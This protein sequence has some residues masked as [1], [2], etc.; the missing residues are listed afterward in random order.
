VLGRLGRDRETRVV[1]VR[2]AR[3]YLQHSGVDG[4]LEKNIIYFPIPIHVLFSCS[5][6]WW[7]QD[8]FYSRAKSDQGFI[9]LGQR[10][11]MP[12]SS[13]KA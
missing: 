12:C 5:Q 3:R 4:L 8:G 7:R 9:A 10:L 11:G 2:L 1:I 6:Q 13:K